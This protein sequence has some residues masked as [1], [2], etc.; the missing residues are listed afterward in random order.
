MGLN[1][2]GGDCRNSWRPLLLRLSMTLRWAF[3]LDMDIGAR[4]DE[5]TTDEE[6]MFMICIIATHLVVSS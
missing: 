6:I 2:N 1:A 5:L 4:C 3:E